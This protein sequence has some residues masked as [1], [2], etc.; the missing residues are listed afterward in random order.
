[1][2]TYRIYRME[3]FITGD[4][5]YVYC[6]PERGVDPRTCVERATERV[7]ELTRLKKNGYE[8][9]GVL[10]TDKEEYLNHRLNQHV[11]DYLYSDHQERQV[12]CNLYQYSPEVAYATIESCRDCKETFL[13]QIVMVVRR[14]NREGLAVHN[15]TASL[16]YAGY[17]KSL[18]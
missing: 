15:P 11:A 1:M 7:I 14:L 12:R 9:T 6:L 16:L 18:F 4:A 10:H 8:V 2:K 13:K 5:Q 3:N 17:V